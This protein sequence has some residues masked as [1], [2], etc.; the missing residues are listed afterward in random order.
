MVL[1]CPLLDEAA[2][3]DLLSRITINL[4]AY[5]VGTR[6]GS[7]AQDQQKSSVKDLVDS[8]A[9]QGNDDPVIAVEANNEQEDSE[10]INPFSRH[11][12]VQWK[13]EVHIGEHY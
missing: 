13:Q 6:H 2:F 11:I 10:A 4:E 12:Y 5:V 1:R 3:T 8:Q 9:L 7:E